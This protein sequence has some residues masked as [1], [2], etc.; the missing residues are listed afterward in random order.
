L[1]IFKDFGLRKAAVLR[2]CFFF[3]A[4]CEAGPPSLR[5]FELGQA[6]A[7]VH[8]VFGNV[9]GEGGGK[10]SS[11]GVSGDNDVV[12]GEVFAGRY[13]GEH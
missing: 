9:K 2:Y 4:G 5:G 13:G 11:E 12:L 10:G 1:Y 8:A 7:G 3:K 6:T